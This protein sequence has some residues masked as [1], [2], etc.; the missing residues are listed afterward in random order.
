MLAD[1]TDKRT[2]K[3]FCEDEQLKEGTLYQWKARYREEIYEEANRRLKNR[4][5]ELRTKG[6]K[7]LDSM[8]DDKTSGSVIKALELFF[9]LNGDLIERTENR[10]ELMRPEDKKIRIAALLEQITAQAGNNEKARKK[11]KEASDESDSTEDAE[12]SGIG[13]DGNVSRKGP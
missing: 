1:P 3:K 10:T 11:A 12:D 2:V 13:G 6:W 5:N 8:M 4:K 9:K 7:R